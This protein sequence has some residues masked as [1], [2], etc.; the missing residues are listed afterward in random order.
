MKLISPLSLS[1]EDVSDVEI[2]CPED[3]AQRKRFLDESNRM[4]L[5]HQRRDLD[6]L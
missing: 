5:T 2:A 1:E 6:S 3:S 4:N